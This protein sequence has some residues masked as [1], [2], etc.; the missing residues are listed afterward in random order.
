MTY[1]DEY[2]FAR[3][4]LSAGEA[5]LWKGKPEKGHIFTQQDLLFIPFSIFWC[6]FAFFWEISVITSGAPFFFAIF[7]IP[8]ICIGLYLVFGRF[9]WTAYIRKRTFYVITNK[10]II[11]AK[12]N[13]I[14]MLEGRTLPPVYVIANRDG[15]GTIRFGHPHY[16]YRRGGFGYAGA[17]P[18][19]FTLENIPDVARVQQIIG[20][21]DR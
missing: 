7:G 16:H 19:L 12:G 13:K 20:T 10:K 9:L 14:D 11:R 18:T 17:Y 8:F 1:T 5:I 21:M 4:Y 6:G 15:S 2:S 3:A